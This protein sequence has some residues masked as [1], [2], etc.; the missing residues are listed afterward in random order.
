MRKLQNGS[1]AHSPGVDRDAMASKA[2]TIGH[3]LERCRSCEQPVAAPVDL[4]DRELFHI[5]RCP[6]CQA[7]NP[8]PMEVAQLAHM[9]RTAILWGIL[10]GALITFLQSSFVNEAFARIPLP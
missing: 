8:H 3:G 6:H 10:G 2:Q 5:S 1:R 9:R 4:L 7:S